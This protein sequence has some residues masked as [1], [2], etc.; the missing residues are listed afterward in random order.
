MKWAMANM[1]DEYTITIDIR[2]ALLVYRDQTRVRA[3]SMDTRARPMVVY[4]HEYTDIKGTAVP[5]PLSQSEHDFVWPRIMQHLMKNRIALKV[6]FTGLRTPRKNA[7]K[8]G[9]NGSLKHPSTN[10]LVHHK[11]LRGMSSVG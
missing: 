9:R 3:F 5:A 4:G 2:H 10:K 8:N 7:K 11:G 6:S 1:K